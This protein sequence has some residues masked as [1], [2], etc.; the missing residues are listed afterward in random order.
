[1]GP[2]LCKPRIFIS[3]FSFS[4][5]VYV[6]CRGRPLYQHFHFPFQLWSS[7]KRRNLL[8]KSK[9]FSFIIGL[10]PEEACF[11]GKPKGSKRI[12]SYE[13]VVVNPMGISLP[14]IQIESNY[15]DVFSQGGSVSIWLQ[16]RMP[17]DLNTLLV[18]IR[19]A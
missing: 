19:F 9:F 17:T 14:L 16:Y 2:L 10:F 7:L 18:K 8:L 3:N 5:L 11:L 6:T 12:A 4:H 13:K 15:N 1:M